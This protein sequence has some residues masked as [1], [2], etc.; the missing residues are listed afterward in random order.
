MP[1]LTISCTAP[2]NAPWVLTVGAGNDKGTPDPDD[3]EIAPFSSRGPTAI[4]AADKPDIIAPGVGVA[5]T[6]DPASVLFATHGSGRIWGSV[7]TASEPY[8]SLSGT[9][10]AA[11]IVA[12]TVALMLQAN[13]SLDPAD[14]K[15][16]LAATA[17]RHPD[18]DA[19]A[20]GA[21]F[22]DARAA[23]E[24]AASARDLMM[25]IHAHPTLSETVGEA[26][27]TLYGTATHLY[28]P[29]K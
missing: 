4:D 15:S 27:E 5:S 29:K 6:A 1:S 17:D 3:D 7:T 21:G 22:L 19:R 20:Q 8:L 28:R 23:V 9:S 14:V 24:M 26:A 18:A 10:M 12:G 11:P 16:I 2:G 13:P 25:I